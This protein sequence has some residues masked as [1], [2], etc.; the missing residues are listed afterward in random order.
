MPCFSTRWIV[1]SPENNIDAG[2]LPCG[3]LKQGTCLPLPKERALSGATMY[4]EAKATAEKIIDRMAIQS[5]PT[6]RVALK[7]LQDFCTALH[8]GHVVNFTEREI[9]VF[10]GLSQVSSASGARI[11]QLSFADAGPPVGTKATNE[12]AIK[13]NDNAELENFEECEE[14]DPKAAHSSGSEAGMTT[15]V[16]CDTAE[17]DGSVA[18]PDRSA[19]QDSTEP[20]QISTE[21]EIASTEPAK[22]VTWSF[23]ERTV[24]NGM[25]K[26]QRKRAQAKQ[27]RDAALILTAKYRQG[28]KSKVVA[29]DDVAALLDGPYIMFHSKSMVDALVLPPVDV[30][31][32]LSVREFDVGQDIPVIKGIPPLPVVMEAIEAIKLKQ[33]IDLLAYWPD[34]GYATFDQLDAMASIH[35]ARQRF[36]LVMRTTKWIDEVEWGVADLR[37]PFTDTCNITKVRSFY[38]IFTEVAL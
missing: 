29:L 14:G 31:G 24:I 26:A 20:T 21:S 18:P 9:P 28:K 16:G 19:S 15:A 23:T 4:S 12:E 8:S 7:W 35:E 33:N 10:S 37:E 11:S 22:A 17:R 25:T 38:G 27:D 30:T 32:P 6:F 1:Q 3:G 5:T 13:V 34:Y 2:D 36:A